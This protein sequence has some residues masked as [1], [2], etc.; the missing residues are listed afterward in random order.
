MRGFLVVLFDQFRSGVPVAFP[1]QFEL[2][3]RHGRVV[4]LSLTSISP[5]PVFYLFY[6]LSFAFLLEDEIEWFC[7]RSSFAIISSSN[8]RD[9]PWFDWGRRIMDQGWLTK[10]RN[11]CYFLLPCDSMY[12]MFSVKYFFVRKIIK[13]NSMILAIFQFYYFNFKFRLIWKK[14]SSE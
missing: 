14:T 11:I 9:Y 7:R 5:S 2:S 8:A 1:E 3:S 6:L 4:C 12:S 13:S 10:M